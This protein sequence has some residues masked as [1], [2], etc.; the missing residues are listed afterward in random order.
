MT[1]WRD[2][3]RPERIALVKEHYT[4]DGSA[5]KIAASIGMGVTRN[6]VVG[7]YER[8][9]DMKLSHPLGGNIGKV[10]SPREKPEPMAKPI[11]RHA[12]TPQPAKIIRPDFRHVSLVDLKSGE[13]KWPDGNSP[14][15]FCGN[16]A[17]GSYCRYH[18]RLSYAVRA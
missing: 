3:S 18:R 6:A 13:C 9:R 4:S 14:Y 11:I 7:I 12:P 1:H 16:E 15:S 2:L 5:A 10:F 8:N 17:D